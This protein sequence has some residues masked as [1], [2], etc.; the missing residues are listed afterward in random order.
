CGLARAAVAHQDAQVL[1]LR[2]DVGQPDQRLR[3]LGR[4]EVEARN[5]RVGERLLG[6]LV[7]IEIIHQ[8]KPILRFLRGAPGGSGSG[9]VPVAAVVPPAGAEETGV[10]PAGADAA[11]RMVTGALADAAAPGGALFV[12]TV[13]LPPAAEMGCE[14]VPPSF[15]TRAATSRNPGSSLPTVWYSS[16]ASAS[17]WSASCAT[18]SSK[19]SAR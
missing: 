17:W 2:A 10:L 13:D 7:V 4:V 8:T 12:G 16:S 14:M 3:V 11:G 15:C 6:Q 5:R 9:C 18:P 1:H 19:E